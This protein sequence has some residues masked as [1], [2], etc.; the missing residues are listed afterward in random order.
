MVLLNLALVHQSFHFLFS[1]YLRFGEIMH[2][3][4][5]GDIIKGINYFIPVN[6]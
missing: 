6:N 2:P 4:D 1:M 3:A 5:F